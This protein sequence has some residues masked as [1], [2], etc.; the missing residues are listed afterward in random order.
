MTEPLSNSKSKNNTCQEPSGASGCLKTVKPPQKPAETWQE[1]YTRISAPG[2]QSPLVSPDDSP[3]TLAECLLASYNAFYEASPP[4]EVW[5]ERVGK[6]LLALPAIAK[7]LDTLPDY[8][9]LQELVDGQAELIQKVSQT[10]GLL[11]DISET[12]NVI[13]G[14]IELKSSPVS[15]G[16]RKSTSPR[17]EASPGL[18]RLKKAKSGGE[19]Q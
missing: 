18:Q 5:A 9:Q 16:G 3:L 15:Q 7:A 19:Q 10:N 4:A 12:L 13:R 1:Y 2:Y 17:T 6:A 11:R 14:Q 8:T